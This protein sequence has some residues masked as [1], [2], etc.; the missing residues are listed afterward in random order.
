MLVENQKINVKW[1][2]S[3]KVHYENKGYQFTNYGDWFVVNAEDLRESSHARVNIICDYCKTHYQSEWRYYYRAVKDGKKCA[4]NNCKTVKKNDVTLI[5]RQALLYDKMLM[6]CNV[7]GYTLITQRDAI[8]NNATYIEYMCPTHGI[9]RMRVYNFINGRHCPQCSLEQRSSRYRLTVDE[10]VRR[11]DRLGGVVLNA[12]EY[13]N[14]GTKN[15]IILCCECGSPFTTSLSCF[16]EH[17][18]QVCQDCSGVESMGE[19]KIRH[20]LENNKIEFVSQKWFSDCRDINPLPFDFY[21]PHYN[22]IIEF[23]G[24][25]H[26]GETNYF[27]YSFEETKKH[28]EI[29]N[30]YCQANGIYL[31]R[32]PHW[33]IDKIEEILDK[34]LILHEDIV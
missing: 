16:E 15:L 14:T 6:Q 30:N 24:R 29:K 9:Q 18:G 27:T 11:I 31:I 32:I 2:Y 12:D 22:T 19:R 34:E 20:F 10:V 26:F 21:L 23:D 4:C 5:G 25:Q 7:N 33:K 1:H 17:G 8:Q 3:N 13:K 28:D